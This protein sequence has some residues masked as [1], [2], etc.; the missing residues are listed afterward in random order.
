[1]ELSILCLLCYNLLYFVTLFTIMNILFVQNQLRRQRIFRDR[2]NPLDFMRED[3]FIA[4][5]R[6][7][8][9]TFI[10]LCDLVHN[11]ERVTNR[12]YALP[13]SLQLAVALR[14]YSQGGYISQSADIHHISKPA[15]AKVLDDITNILSSEL[16]NYV[17]FPP[18][19]T[20]QQQFYIYGQFPRIIGCIDGTH[21]S[22]KKPSINPHIY[23]NRKSRASI[24]VLLV[25]GVNMEIYYCLVRYPGSC[26]DSYILNNSEL[27]TEFTNNP[28]NGWLLGDPGYPLRRWLL[29]PL[30]EVNTPQELVYQT[31]H[32][33]CRSIIERCNGLLKGRFRCILN[34]LEFE[35]QKACKIIRACILLHNVAI[36]TNQNFNEPI[37]I[38]P[39]EQENQFMPENDGSGAQARQ[40]LIDTFV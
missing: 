26:H 25:C 16:P 29:T 6:F 34:T 37:P 15:A 3:L 39:H 19:D 10:E 31:R 33:R 13:V 23:I 1:M 9:H 28:P 24:N 18:H 12:N 22:I 35:P 20:I 2:Y 32:T 5:Y 38:L 8:K 14:F 40:F 36:R 11:V 27:C 4:R 30:A 21:V 7:T 17:N